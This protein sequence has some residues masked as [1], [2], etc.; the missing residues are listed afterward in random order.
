M[1]ICGF[2]QARQSHRSGEIAEACE[3]FEDLW[4][5]EHVERLGV[6]CVGNYKPL[7]N[8]SAL[9]ACYTFA[10]M[11]NKNRPIAFVVLFS[12]L[13]CGSSC[14]A[15]SSVNKEQ[16]NIVVILADDMDLG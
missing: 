13:F 2:E 7:P 1:G 9:K 5:F 8:R 6:H 4:V 10:S 14:D 12:L 11:R 16:P 3:P 15:I